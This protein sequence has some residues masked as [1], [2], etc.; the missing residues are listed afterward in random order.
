MADE[1]SKTLVN[2]AKAV[3]TLLPLLALIWGASTMY[4]QVQR[5]TKDLTELKA[6]QST[7]LD[8]LT[9]QISDLNLSIRELQV[10][11]RMLREGK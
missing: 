1:T 11:V 5:N 4:S 10:Q 3:I 2:W 6:Q 8:R 7:Q 9:A